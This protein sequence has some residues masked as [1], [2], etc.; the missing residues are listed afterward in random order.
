MVV[1]SIVLPERDRNSFTLVWLDSRVDLSEDNIHTQ[2][3]LREA[4]EDLK[5]FTELEQCVDYIRMSAVSRIVLIVSGQLGEEILPVIHAHPL[6]TAVYVFCR[7]RERN[8]KWA[9]QYPKV[10]KICWQKNDFQL[11]HFLLSLCLGKTCDGETEEINR[12]NPIRS[13]KKN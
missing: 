8:E 9:Y 1:P 13:G 10:R 4:F 2:T 6:L 12:P 11:F 7:D 5:T 3:L